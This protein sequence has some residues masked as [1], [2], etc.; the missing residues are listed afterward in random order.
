VRKRFLGA[1]LEPPCP[2]AFRRLIYYDNGMQQPDF[3]FSQEYCYIA[4]FLQFFPLFLQLADTDM[5]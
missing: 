5:Q 3:L 2:A 4:A 1:P